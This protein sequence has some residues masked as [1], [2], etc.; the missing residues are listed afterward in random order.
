[1]AKLAGDFV[2][3][4]SPLGESR[5]EGPERGSPFPELTRRFRTV[6]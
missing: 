2:F 6:G 3:P 4:H 5:P 1:M